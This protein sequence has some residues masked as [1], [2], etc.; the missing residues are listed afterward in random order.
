MNLLTKYKLIQKTI[1][2]DNLRIK[3]YQSENLDA[4][5][6]AM[7]SVDFGVDERFPYFVNIWESGIQLSNFFLKDYKL[8]NKNIIELGSGGGIVGITLGL[9][10]NHVL[11]TDFETD[12]LKLCEINA[13]LNKFKNYDTLLCDWRNFPEIE[14][15]FDYII[16]SDLLYEKRF[17]MPLYNT[18]K[19]FINKGCVFILSDP[20]R[21]HIMEFIELFKDDNYKIV[22]LKKN[23]KVLI[24]EIRL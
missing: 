14:K 6:D 19:P 24:Y 17:V 22:Q 11:F 15:D 16:G 2:L 10:G 7:T 8:S 21:N 5:F 23:E 20:G 1:K 13:Y 12:A 9:S 3:L 4:Y 18:V